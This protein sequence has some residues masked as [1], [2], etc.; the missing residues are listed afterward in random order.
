MSL[1]WI[2]SYPKSGNTWL[3]FFLYAYFRGEIKSSTK[4]ENFIPDIHVMSGPE[5]LHGKNLSF[6]KSHFMFSDDF[7]SLV[8][9]SKVIYIFRHPKSVLLS[10]INY[11]KIRGD[12][13]ID[14]KSFVEQFIANKGVKLW[15]ENRMGT[16]SEHVES[17]LCQRSM[18]IFVIQYEELKLSSEK[19]FSRV[20]G[21]IGK[22]PVSKKLK[23]AIHLSSFTSMRALEKKEKR[24][25]IFNSVF[26]GT[27]ES[28]QKGLWFMQSGEAGATLEHIDPALDHQFDEAFAPYV[29]KINELKSR[30]IAHTS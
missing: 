5:E 23:R 12:K 26:S 8:P 4:V 1:C 25:N 10:N 27:N 28:T 21:F 24:K 6:A 29:Q 30:L 22:E 18:P 15:L 9:D 7:A 19:I 14:D 17:W 16:W 3:R 2:A 20:I 13:S 11:F